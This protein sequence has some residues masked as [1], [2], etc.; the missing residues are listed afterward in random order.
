MML[1][2][3][4][5]S[6]IFVIGTEPILFTMI[7]AIAVYMRLLGRIGYV[8]DNNSNYHQLPALYSYIPVDLWLVSVGTF[9]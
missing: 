5:K 3:I 2:A 4:P 7:G 8:K 9:G 6:G 1:G